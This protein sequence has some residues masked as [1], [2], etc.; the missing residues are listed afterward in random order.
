MFVF[1]FLARTAYLIYTS[2]TTGHTMSVEKLTDD[3]LKTIAD[4]PPTPPKP[5]YVC[6]CPRKYDWLVE[7][8]DGWGWMEIGGDGWRWMEMDESSCMCMFALGDSSLLHPHDAQS[9]H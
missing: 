2:T 6:V 3:Y 4:A 5:M 1:M 7:W 8:L 9:V